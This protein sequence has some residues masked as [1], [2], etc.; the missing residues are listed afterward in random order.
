M[1]HQPLLL[2][3]LQVMSYL[4]QEVLQ[5]AL[6]LEVLLRSHGTFSDYEGNQQLPV[7]TLLPHPV[8]QHL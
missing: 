8:R 6:P 3:P 5:A 7:K 2:L 1:A 4:Y